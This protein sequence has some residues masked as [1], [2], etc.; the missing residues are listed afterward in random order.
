MYSVVQ[1]IHE[2]DCIFK[3]ELKMIEKWEHCVPKIISMGKERN[4]KIVERIPS[5]GKDNF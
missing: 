2:M 4:V 5:A 3:M 1:I